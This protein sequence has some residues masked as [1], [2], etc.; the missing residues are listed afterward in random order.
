MCGMT[1]WTRPTRSDQPMGAKPNHP[2]TFKPPLK[3]SFPRQPQQTGKY[4]LYQTLDAYSTRSP[5]A[6]KPTNFTPRPNTKNPPHGLKW[7]K[8][9][10]RTKSP[11]KIARLDAHLLQKKIKF[12]L[13]FNKFKIQYKIVKI[14]GWRQ[15][16]WKKSMAKSRIV[17]NFSTVLGVD[18]SKKF[19]TCLFT[20]IKITLYFFSVALITV[21]KY[22]KMWQKIKIFSIFFCKERE[23]HFFL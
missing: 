18:K 8:S 4:E 5:I 17:K 12:S 3:P 16:G 19:N 21:E 22:R 1:C 23:K 2:P 9:K 14:L 13:S 7:A 20:N 10:I 15:V 6:T 11:A